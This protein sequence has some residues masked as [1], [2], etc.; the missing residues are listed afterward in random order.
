M[1]SL[2]LILYICE[3]FLPLRKRKLFDKISFI[4]GLTN[5][6]LIFFASLFIKLV[7][8]AI[9]YYSIDV[10]GFEYSLMSTLNLSGPTKTI[11]SIV[12]FDLLIWLQHVASHHIP[13]LWRLHKVHHCDT[14]LDTSSGLR[15]HPIEIILSMFYKLLLIMLIGISSS[16][17]LMFEVILTGFALFNHSNIKLNNTIDTYLSYIIVTPNVHQV[18]HSNK[19]DETNSNF[20]FNIVIW[21]RVFGTYKEYKRVKE[22]LEIGL[23]GVSPEDANSLIFL[24]LWPLRRK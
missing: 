19:V 4:H 1:T 12:I 13:I 9:T 10:Y 3:V 6:G 17:F 22:N 20:G 21:D 18:H 11:L 7:T 23:K 15:F 5:L 14:F 2:I 8:L 24:L 16:D